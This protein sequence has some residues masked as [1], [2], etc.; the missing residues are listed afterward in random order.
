MWSKMVKSAGS[1][2]MHIFVHIEIRPCYCRFGGN[3]ISLYFGVWHS[4]RGEAHEEAVK[5]WTYVHLCTSR[6]VMLL[7]VQGVPFL[8][9]LGGAFFDPF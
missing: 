6:Y 3:W 2:L 1:G 7:P 8:P 4:C 5:F 9:F